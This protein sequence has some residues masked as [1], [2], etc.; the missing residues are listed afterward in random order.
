VLTDHGP[1]SSGAPLLRHTPKSSSPWTAREPRK[2]CILP[3]GC[4]GVVQVIQAFLR[5]VGLA[6]V[7]QG[8][9]YAVD[10]IVVPPA[11]EDKVLTSSSIGSPDGCGSRGISRAVAADG[12]IELARAVRLAGC[13][14][15]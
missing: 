6:L 2:G 5:L 1:H 13:R 8:L 3:E 12:R 15:T 4:H 14:R 11:W 7:P 9:A 10:L